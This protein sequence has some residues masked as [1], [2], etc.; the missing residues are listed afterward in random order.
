MY[1]YHWLKCQSWQSQGPLNLNFAKYSAGL[2]SVLV[3]YKHDTAHLSTIF[4]RVKNEMIKV[5]ANN[6]SV[7]TFLILEYW[8]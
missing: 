4:G 5:V 8:R 6:R 7:G 1:V 2:L 3:L